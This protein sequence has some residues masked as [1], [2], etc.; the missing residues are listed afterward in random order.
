[1]EDKSILRNG[2]LTSR[3]PADLRSLKPRTLIS[4]SYLTTLG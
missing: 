3:I 1:M 2:L 4:K